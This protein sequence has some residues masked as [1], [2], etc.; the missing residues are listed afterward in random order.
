MYRHA[1]MATEHP[2]LDVRKRHAYAVVQK[3]RELKPGATK[4][5]NEALEATE[6]WEGDSE[7]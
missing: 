1:K 3:G 5:V 4:D 6:A 2:D 7:A